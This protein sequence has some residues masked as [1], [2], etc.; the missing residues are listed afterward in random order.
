MLRIASLH[1]YPVKACAGVDLEVM[2][3]D[4]RG[5]TGDRRYMIVDPE[6]R[7]VTQRESPAMAL[8]QPSLLPA[9][10]RMEAPGRAPLTVQPGE[11]RRPVRVW[12]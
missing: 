7:F 6:G 10:L 1:I 9:G 12:S 3:L 4:E 2:N 5:P 11:D 8:I